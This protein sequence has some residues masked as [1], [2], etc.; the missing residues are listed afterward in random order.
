MQRLGYCSYNQPSYSQLITDADESF[1]N[2]SNVSH[3]L[4]PPITH[5]ASRVAVAKLLGVHL[6]HDVNFSQQVESVVAIFNK[7]L[8]LLAQLEKGLGISALDSVLKA[9]VLNKILCAL[10]VYFGYLT[11]GQRGTCCSECCIELAAEALPR[12]TM[13]SIH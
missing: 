8:Y 5:S 4:L 2:A 6:R 1:S 10:P 13:I 3:D 7:R 9:I 12:F 11:E